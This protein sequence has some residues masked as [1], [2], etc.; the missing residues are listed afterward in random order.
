MNTGNTG[1][2]VGDLVAQAH[3]EGLLSAASAQA[4][5]A[6][7]LG[8]QIQ[9]ALG[10]DVDDVPASEVV[11]VTMMPD[12][13]GSISAANNEQAVRDGHNL[14]LDTLAASR[15]RE[16]ILVHTRYLNGRILYPYA[17][18]EES[19][20]MDGS[21]YQACLGTP[22]Y[23]Q[24]VVLLGTVVAKAQQFARCGVPVRTVTLIIT[25]GADEGSHRHGARDVAALVRDMTLAETHIVAALGIDNGYTDF[26]RV[27]REMGI[28]D[29]WILTPGHS[30]P[31]I[32]RAFQLF[33]QSAVQA[34]RAGRFMG[35]ALG[36]FGA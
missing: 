23:D 34:S 30:A 22:L 19:V 4:L 28:A 18:L 9:A 16:A 12:D 24:S 1:M 31:D 32:R 17:V 8:A 35:T 36:G 3:E 27:F 26:R 10:V 20:R 29:R 6:V 14:V 15:E 2:H 11:L 21:N 13:S 33:S 25:D 7:D 5:S